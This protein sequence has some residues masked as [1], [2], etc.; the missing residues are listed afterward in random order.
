MSTHGIDDMDGYVGNGYFDTDPEGRRILAE[1]AIAEQKCQES[2]REETER[3][4]DPFYCLQ[5]ASAKL[6]ALTREHTKL[7]KEFEILT[8]EVAQAS[9]A[10][11]IAKQNALAKIQTM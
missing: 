5:K 9:A 10:V 1:R 2:Q 4:K 6:N 3:M 8:K 11:E 7:Q